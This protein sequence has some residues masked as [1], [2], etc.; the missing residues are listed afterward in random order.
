MFA[1]VPRN[2]RQLLALLCVLHFGLGAA[3]GLSVD[4]A[5]YA[6]YAAHPDWSYFDHPPLVGWAQWPLVALGA[7]TWALRL[8]PELLWLATALVV[9]Q[10]AERLQS[11]PGV[12]AA[13]RSSQVKEEPAQRAGD[14]EQNALP[15][16]RLPPPGQAGAWAV[17]ALALA[18]LLH[19]L[20]I[21]LLPDTLLVFFTALL[22]WATLDLMDATAVCRPVPWLVMGVLL[23][24]AGLSKYTAIFAALA[25]AACLLLAHGPV[26]LRNAWAWLALAIAVLLVMPVAYWNHA[27][28]WISFTYQAKHG[29]GGGWQ[30]GHV[31]RFMVVQLLVYGP[32]LLWGWAGWRHGVARS[33]RSLGL[34]FVLPFAVLA[35]LSGGGTSLPHWTAPAWVALAPF[36][37]IGL[38][39]AQR[40]RRR[41]VFRCMV[42][43]QAL[44]CAVVLGL[45][46]T[47]GQPFITN[48]TGQGNS[49]QPSN[50][51]ADVHGW[52]AAGT[53]AR[54]LAEQHGLRSVAVQNWTLA[55]RLGWYARPLPVFVLEDRFDQF[56]L[57]AGDLP[58]GADTLL[59]D[60]S[61]LGYAVPL[62]P[63]GFAEC[64]LLGTQNVQRLGKPLASFRFYAC[65][66]WSGQPQPRLLGTP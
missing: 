58:A 27:N 26:L 24:L 48:T 22:V 23:G 50:P 11:P 66:N 53:R 16:R 17:L 1:S 39:H 25:V 40:Q 65:R 3:L 46:L 61:Q 54:T 64:T 28:G 38:A 32:L 62:G 33:R 29:A 8:V 7:P 47:G 12:W 5:H 9:Y 35:V 2:T 14:T 42:A 4:E 57:W 6:L 43:A 60:W 56:D 36:A 44:L 59:L 21:G 51:F 31:L 45:M 37:G 41:W 55:S 63:L 34:F 10:L 49:A 52:D 19:V 15:P 30:A 20:G 18:P 13:E